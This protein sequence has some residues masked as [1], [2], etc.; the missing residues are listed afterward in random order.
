L[1]KAIKKTHVNLV[2]LVDRP[3]NIRIFATEVALS[4]YTK[5][6]GKIFPKKNA[7]AGGLLKYL[8]R[9]IE[10]PDA[11]RGARHARVKRRRR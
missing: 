1:E 9:N 2:D 7:Y 3:N 8:L 11:K 4:D 10:N 6:K 5:E